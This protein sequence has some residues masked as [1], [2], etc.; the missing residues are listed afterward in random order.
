MVLHRTSCVYF[1][2]RH[3]FGFKHLDCLWVILGNNPRISQI[4]KILPEFC[5]K[6]LNLYASIYGNVF[7][8]F[9]TLDIFVSLYKYLYLFICFHSRVDLFAAY[10]LYPV[11]KDLFQESILLQETKLVSKSLIVHCLDQKNFGV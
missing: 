5:P 11:Q 4:D 10:L 6:C 8:N 7:D 9:E 3:N 1:R 2:F